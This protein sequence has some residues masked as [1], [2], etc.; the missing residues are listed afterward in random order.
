[1]E[2]Q[3]VDIDIQREIWY[4]EMCVYTYIHKKKLERLNNPMTSK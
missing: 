3:V 2:N 1:M 4:I